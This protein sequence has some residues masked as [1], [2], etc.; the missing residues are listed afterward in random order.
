[1]RRF[2]GDRWYRLGTAPWGGAGAGAGGPR[3]L[4]GRRAGRHP[5]GG[6][7][8]TVV[9]HLG[10]RHPWAARGAL[11]CLGPDRGADR[12]E[13]SPGTERLLRTPRDLRGHRLTSH[14][15]RLTTHGHRLTSHAHRLTSHGH[16]LTTHATARPL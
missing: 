14:A 15:H 16:R 5:R 11:P 8:A 7:L 10:R 13:C 1:A 6:H 2:R 12:G 9:L 4:A 3:A